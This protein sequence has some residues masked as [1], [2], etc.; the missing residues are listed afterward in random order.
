M[1]LDTRILD[2]TERYADAVAL[3]SGPHRVTY[4][5][6]GAQVRKLAEEIRAA[7]P[8]SVAAIVPVSNRPGDYVAQVAAW[9]A[10]LVVVPVHRGTP[11]ARLAA[12][13]A[14]TG[15]RLLVGQ[16]V[17]A[18]WSGP[19]E[20]AGEAAQVHPVGTGPS[21]T[22]APLDSDQALVVFTSGSTA[23]P[24]G[25]VLSHA[26]FIGKLATIETVLPFPAGSTTLQVLQPHF[27]FGQWTSLLTLLSGATLLLR[28]RF[29][30]GDVL[31]TLVESDVARIA[32]VPT[33]ARMLLRDAPAEGTGGSRPAPLWICGGEV[34][35]P[36]V[37]EGLGRLLPGS[38]I[39]D[40]YGLSE[41]CTSDFIVPP[42]EYDKAAGTIGRPSPNVMAAVVDEHRQPVPPGEVG[43]LALR[44][45]YL[46]TGYLGDAA[47]TAAAVRDG[48]LYTGDLGRLRA[49]GR[50]ELAGRS[51]TLISRGGIKLSPLEIENAYAG[52]PG[53]AEVIAVGIPDAVFGERVHLL[54]VPDRAAGPAARL[55]AERMRVWGRGRLEPAKVPDVFHEIREIPLG[56]T[57]KTDRRAARQLVLHPEA[58]RVHRIR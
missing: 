48:W 25:V 29:D 56:Q 4:A 54:I 10:G 51:K 12:I 15:A 34:L 19:V 58:G 9:H 31:R 49:D 47:A 23:Q 52:C 16:D 22:P 42:Q 6:F 37:G 27:S 21:A 2:A 18:T 30:T 11:A 5:Q 20:H 45:P 7:G 38:R 39:A 13:V 33:M 50:V 46:M 40:V 14:Q 44:T 43:E 32:V 8:R 24:K 55:T 41:S 1:R 35:P 3:V 36:A 26:A 57:G 53:C 17:P 28:E